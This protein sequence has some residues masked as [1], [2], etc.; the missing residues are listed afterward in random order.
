MKNK[1]SVLHVLTALAFNN[2]AAGWKL[3][4]NGAIVMRDGNPVFLDSAGKEM[5][6]DQ[7]TISRLNGE[8]KNHRIAKEEAENRLRAF[9]GIDPDAARKAIETVTKL[10]A[11]K[12][13][14]SG[15][16]DKLRQDIGAQYTKQLSDK[17]TAISDLQKRIDDMLIG[18]VFNQSEFVRENI[19][20]PREMFE[21]TFRKNFKVENGKVVALDNAGNILLSK[22]R[23][24]ENATPEE[25]LSLLVESYP[26][27]DVIMRAQ[28]NSGTGSNG[29][30]GNRPGGARSLK[31]ADF[32]NL[33]PAQ[34]AEVAA[35][36]GRGELSLTD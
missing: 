21:A 28:T 23:V 31:R 11:K 4:E 25:A 22:T 5:T 26:Q 27:K 29:Q 30:G 16:V 19:V 8:A 24:G 7:S 17:D 35:K 6:V 33:A 18:S 34:K 32:D 14:D 1:L 10:D 2:S 36:V 9:E 3:D 15:E 13:I 20:V 12:L